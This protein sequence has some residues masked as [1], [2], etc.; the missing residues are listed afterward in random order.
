VLQNATKVLNV[1]CMMAVFYARVHD[2]AVQTPGEPE[3]SRDYYKGVTKMLRKCHK[4][5]A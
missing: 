5:V 2:H 4:R 3:V 1:C